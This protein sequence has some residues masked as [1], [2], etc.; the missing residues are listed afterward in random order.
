[1][2]IQVEEL[3]KQCKQG[4]CRAFANVYDAFSEK[5]YKY[6]FYRTFHRETAED[7]TS[8]TF[9][10][11]LEKIHQYKPQKG[12]FSAWI[13]RIARN[14][15]IDHFRTTGKTVNISDIKE[16]S[17]KVDIEKDAVDR[18]QIERIRT[19]MQ[20]LK[21]MQR[22]IIL[23]R[24][25]QDLPYSEIAEITGKSEAS[26]KMTFSRTLVRLRHDLALAV[27]IIILFH[28]IV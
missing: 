13:F 17:G 14:Q 4:D 12:Q 26:C 21:P 23:L 25:W 28:D 16:I 27:I 1:M 3:V 10:K 5:I 9:L 24:V 2:D 18:E 19:L 6:I 15:V 7:L 8:R 11:V 20:K 22:E